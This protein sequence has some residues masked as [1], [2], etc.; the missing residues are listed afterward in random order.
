MSPV[1]RDALAMRRAWRR[2]NAARWPYAPRG[3][4]ADPG[5]PSVDMAN[6]RLHEACG[7]WGVGLTAED[8]EEDPC[9]RL[10]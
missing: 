4:M 1:V 9:V 8:Y 3:G 10:P 2:W 5:A 6:R 7:C